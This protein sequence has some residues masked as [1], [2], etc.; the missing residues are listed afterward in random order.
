VST[1]LFLCGLRLDSL[2]NSTLVF[3]CSRSRAVNLANEF[4]LQS[5]MAN[6]ARKMLV[7]RRFDDAI[8]VAQICPLFY[9]RMTTLSLAWT[10]TRARCLRPPKRKSTKRS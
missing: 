7:T 6:K 3:C 8:P 5:D 10:M 4:N 1:Q 9:C 2:L